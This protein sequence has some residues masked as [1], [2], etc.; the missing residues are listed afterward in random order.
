MIPDMFGLLRR[1]LARPRAWILIADSGVRAAGFAMTFL[2]SRFGGPGPVGQYSML[3][4]TASTVIQPFL[5]VMMNTA[6]V[7]SMASQRAAPGTLD[8]T[9]RG[10]VAIALLLAGLSTP[11]FLIL[12]AVTRTE[13]IGVAAPAALALSAALSLMAGQLVTATLVGTNYAA[14]RFLATARVL[15]ACSVTATALS[16]PAVI[17][18]DL[19]GAYAGLIAFSL[20]PP[21]LLAR[22]WFSLSTAVLG[23]RRRDSLAAFKAALGEVRNGLP[24]IAS[25]I[26]G[27]G[28]YWICTIYLVQKFHGLEGV[29]LIAIAAQWLTAILMAATS[30]GRIALPQLIDSA[31]SGDINGFRRTFFSLLWRNVTITLAGA[32]VVALAAQWIAQIYGISDPRLSA[33]IQ[34]NALTAAL[35]SGHFIL[36]RSLVSVSRQSLWL[37]F[38]LVRFGIQLTITVAFIGKSLVVVPIASM[39]GSLALTA[40]YALA[41]DR[42]LLRAL[43]VSSCNRGV[44]S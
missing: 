35:A 39:I 6:T 8:A 44:P 11:I 37:K 23:V 34:W 19:R 7:T 17:L 4:N 43:P 16:I 38:S 13:S 12:L 18:W 2:L 28:V 21:V 32:L 15:I 30:W 20:A 5:P 27:A 33:L 41:F 10:N 1:T 40:L 26:V 9:I 14:Q 24:T 22:Q 25:M 29:G 42:V 31:Q 36:E 3:I